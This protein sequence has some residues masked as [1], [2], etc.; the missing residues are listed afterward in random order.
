[1]HKFF[2]RDLFCGTEGVIHITYIHL[3]ISFSYKPSIWV[4]WIYRGAIV[5]I[6]KEPV[7]I[8]VFGLVSRRLFIISTLGT[9]YVDTTIGSD[10]S[11]P[12]N[13]FLLYLYLSFS[14]CRTYLHLLHTILSCTKSGSFL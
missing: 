7:T 4:V 5:S 14:L 1:M 8:L 3:V 9:S 2:K 11:C 12:L 13:F 6:D 10:L